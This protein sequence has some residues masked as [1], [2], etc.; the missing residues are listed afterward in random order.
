MAA[1]TDTQMALAADSK[2]IRRLAA[3]FNLEAQVVIAEPPATT[4]HILRRQLAQS[5]ITGGLMVSSQFALTI[6]LSTNLMA[7]NTT[8]DFIQLAVVT[9]AT[10]AAIR[11]EIATL[12]NGFAGV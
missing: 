12:W 4:N 10:D 9:D 2:F 7:A 1:T 11:S 8:Y 6:A 3:L 5:C